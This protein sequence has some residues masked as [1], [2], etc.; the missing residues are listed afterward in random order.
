MRERER[1]KLEKNCMHLLELH[2]EVASLVCFLPCPT[3][4]ALL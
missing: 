3:C 1:D 4:S 2:E